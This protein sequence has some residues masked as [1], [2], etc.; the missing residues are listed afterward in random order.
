M[1]KP[2]TKTES[3]CFICG[4]EIPYSPRY[5]ER[6]C[7]ACMKMAV[8]EKGEKLSF[9]NEAM[10]GGFISYNESTKTNGDEHTC[11]IKGYECYA[12]EA[13]MGGIVIV[14]T[15][16]GKE[17][18]N[19]RQKQ[20]SKIRNMVILL[21][22]ILAPAAIWGAYSISRN[23]YFNNGFTLLDV[24][25]IIGSISLL[26]FVSLTLYRYKI[27]LWLA[28]LLYAA[29][30]Y[31]TAYYYGYRNDAFL[32]AVAIIGTTSAALLINYLLFSTGYIGK[33]MKAF[34]ERKRSGTAPWILLIIVPVLLLIAGHIFMAVKGEERAEKI[35]DTAP[36]AATI[37]TVKDVREYKTITRH[38]RNAVHNDALLQYMVNGDKFYR[39]LDNQNT[40]YTAG[41]I[42]EI[43]YVVDEPY[44][45]RV[46]K[47]T[48]D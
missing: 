37:A 11:Y 46:V 4:K 25:M 45:I 24:L 42:L 6:L 28:G 43:Q 22:A 31:Y 9:Y 18:K 29:T 17:K 13:Y 23:G 32:S 16:K 33:K 39:I 15:E 14:P 7:E 10:S 47:T 20:N 21:S 30:G 48:S 38:R 35:L 2:D 3:K 40:Q 27:F 34:R 1:T 36:T 5:P 19:N 8:N 44:M 26:L 41:S 12:K